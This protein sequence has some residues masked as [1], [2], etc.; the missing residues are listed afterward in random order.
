[1]YFS[2]YFQIAISM[3]FGGC[4]YKSLRLSIRHLSIIYLLCFC[5][6]TKFISI[7]LCCFSQ[8]LWKAFLKPELCICQYLTLECESICC[9]WTSISP[10]F[11]YII[12]YEAESPLLFSIFNIIS[13]CPDTI[14]KKHSL[15]TNLKCCH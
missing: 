6:W 8:W 7:F 15:S 13:F 12:L 3:N 5:W 9:F 14:W 10:G 1:M 11:H 4:N 2:N